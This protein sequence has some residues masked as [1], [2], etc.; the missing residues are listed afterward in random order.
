MRPHAAS[1]GVVSSG[2]VS[3]TLV[4]PYADAVIVAAG[5]GLRMGG[6]DKSAL[7]VGGRPMLR[8][9]VDAMRA[10]R[11][12][13]RIVVVT[14]A[15]RVASVRAL[16]WLA[17]EVVV[18]PGG[19]R[20]QESVAAGVRATD[21]EVVLVHDVARPLASPALADRVA[22]AAAAHGAAIPVLAVPDS[23]KRVDGGVVSG[24]LDRAGVARAQTPQGARRA[25]LLPALEALADGSET[26]GD[27]AEVLA[28]HGIA[29]RTVPGEPGAL[30]VTDPADLPVVEAFAR[31]AAP[32]HGW[33]VDSHPFGPTDGLRLGAIE[34][35]EAPRLHGHSDGDVV[36][37]ALCDAL[38]GAARMGDLGRLFPA[39]ERR[40]RG[41]DSRELV[42]EVVVRLAAAGLRPVRAD[43][44]IR[45]ARP[46]LGGGRLD[47]MAHAIAGLLGVEPDA[48]ALSAA[49][50]NLSG[51]EGAGRV[52]S[53]T[54]LV[55]VA[56]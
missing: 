16:S 43:I 30:K 39:G 41:I 14:A 26:F 9:A 28:R 34:I 44:A 33:G 18:V 47:G 45:G 19:A 24:S 56:G 15:D 48:V 50:G 10:A 40:T 13:R 1:D 20:R 38:L 5:V 2:A 37:H 54:A 42:R 22:E 4:A 7:E 17:P 11:S 55:E 32:R 51:D 49:T 12:V 29:V 35:A 8:W 21:A 52:I 23:L 3:S 31:S 53:A 25:L 46:R 6:I 36:L 27:E